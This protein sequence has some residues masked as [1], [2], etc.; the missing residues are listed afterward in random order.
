MV[1][2]ENT[3]ER[4]D[5]D[6][7]LMDVHDGNI[8][9]WVAGGRY[10]WYGMGYR[11]CTLEWSPMPPQYCP[12]VWATFGGCGFRVDHTLSIYSS[13][14]L[15]S[16]TYEGDG[17]PEAARPSGIY[18]RPK[19]VF[20]PRTFEYVLWINY[21]K[22][23]GGSW[24]MSTPLL[25][26]MGNISYVVARASS[27]TGPFTVVN[28][29]ASVQVG[30]PGDNALLVVP[31]ASAPSQYAAY[32]AYDAWDNG[33]RVRVERLTDD[34]SDALPATAKGST[35]GDL[36]EKDVEAPMLF[37]RHGWYYLVYGNTCCFCAE[38]G[39]AT[40]LVARHPLG[41]WSDTGVDLNP[42][43][44]PGCARRIPSQNNYVMQI[45]T[46]AGTR[47]IFTADMWTT[48]P[49]GLKSHDLQYWAPLRFDD[50]VSPPTIAPLEW[51]DGFEL[52][53]LPGG[54][55]GAGA[56]VPFARSVEPRAKIRL[57]QGSCIKNSSLH[58][59]LLAPVAVLT[60]ALAVLLTLCARRCY[61]RNECVGQERARSG[62]V[63][64]KG[65][66]PQL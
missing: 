47:Y 20:D 36:S 24:P 29:W 11:N 62:C 3:A 52:D 6:G 39:G 56:P 9:Q 58:P 4:Y 22:K 30:G 5:V 10:Y 16:W 50:S 13:P 37:E 8:A 19:V 64:S 41:P 35:S 49:D 1:Y 23:S 32:L 34:W 55:R 38:G 7:R 53:V 31:D 66:V 15:V 51:E 44:S 40:V 21:L 61:Q 25:S 57:N 59:G 33:H 60:A 2:I 14:D 63:P 43:S 26:Y 27:P 45:A 18:F 28:P 46:P 48:A 42:R 65:G 17:L 54:G 12:G